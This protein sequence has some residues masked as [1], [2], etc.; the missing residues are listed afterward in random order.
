VTSRLLLVLDSLLDDD[1]G[2]ETTAA[3]ELGW[4]VRR[5]TGSHEELG[6]ADAVVHVRTAVDRDLLSQLAACRV[7]G[8]FG[9]GVD[10]VDLTAAEDARIAVVN[11]T[12]YCV[13]ELSNHTLGLGLALVHQLGPRH[14]N[15]DGQRHT[16]QQYIAQNS[17]A[18]D[19]NALVIGLGAVGRHLARSLVALG[20]RTMVA[21]RRQDVALDPG[22]TAVDL[23][24]G[25]GCAD[26][27][28][29]QRELGPAT[30]GFF[31]EDLIR[32]L[33]PGA[34]VVNT[35]RVGLL[36]EAAVA[37]AVRDQTLGGLGLDAR[38]LPE[39]PLV[40]VLE[41]PHVLV[42][43]HIGWYSERSLNELRRR[44][45]T[46]TISTYEQISHLDTE[47]DPRHALN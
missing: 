35:A 28:F 1:L 29:L 14:D 45:V 36:D 31:N 47:Q 30:R 17:R 20:W 6:T 10:S 42:T 2:V 38:L 46:N 11:V 27:V 26:I 24:Q 39:S 21:S 5:W 32:C 22:M 4:A 25:L 19:T 33:R 44:T 3:A 40:G 43:P 34:I 15:M 12:D 8:R 23:S 13:A 41:H 9:T 18:G 37:T 16:W 7:V